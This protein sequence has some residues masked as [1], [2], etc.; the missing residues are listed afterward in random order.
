MA[1]NRNLSALSQLEREFEIEM[2]DDESEAPRERNDYALETDDEL[3][4]L[5]T[6]DEFE[7]DEELDDPRYESGDDAVAQEYVDRLM[8]LSAREFE[9]ESEVDQALNE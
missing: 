4:E 7:K 1:R 6:D 3:D 2:E 8:E 5:E 9:S